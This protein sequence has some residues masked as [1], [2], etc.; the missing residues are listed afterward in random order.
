[1]HN[2]QQNKNTMKTL[3]VQLQGEIYYVSPLFGGSASDRQIVERSNLFS[4]C[5]SM[6]KDLMFNF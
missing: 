6:S 5:D 1:M 3:F 4:M 2:N